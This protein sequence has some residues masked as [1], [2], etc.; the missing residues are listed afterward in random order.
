MIT[1]RKLLPG[2]PGKL[3]LPV[4]AC[5]GPERRPVRAPVSVLVKLPV[6]FGRS[7]SS[8]S[9]QNIFSKLGG[10]NLL[11]SKVVDLLETT[12]V[13]GKGQ[14]KAHGDSLAIGVFKC[15]GNRSSK[16]TP[17]D[18]GATTFIPPEYDTC[19]YV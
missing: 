18:K 19:G 17:R 2:K 9:Q 4:Y 12:E 16:K 8:G 7:G 5:E 13:S 14:G 6:G 15:S 11:H 3:F 10:L 1:A